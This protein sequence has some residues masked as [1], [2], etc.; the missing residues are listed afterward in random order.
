MAQ[1][2]DQ[3]KRNSVIA[4]INSSFKGDSQPFA[5]PFIKQFIDDNGNFKEGSSAGYGSLGYFINNYLK[6]G[7]PNAISDTAL[8][9][10]LD[11]VTSQGYNVDP[12]Y[13]LSKTPTAG[14][15]GTYTPSTPTAAPGGTIPTQ[16]VPSDVPGQ[17]IPGPN[18]PIGSDRGQIEQEAAREKE[19]TLNSVNQAA[20]LRT[21][22]IS[23]LGDILNKQNQ[24]QFNYDLPGIKEDLGNSGLFTSPSALAAAV[25]RESGMLGANTQSTLAQA[26]LGNIDLQAQGLLGATQA[27]TGM[28]QGGLQRLFS[29]SDYDK[30]AALAREIGAQM[31]PNS[32]SS[33]S[34]ALTGGLGGAASGAMIGSAVPGIGTGIGAGVGGAI[35]L[36]GGATRNGGGG[37]T[38]ICTAMK[39][40]GILTQEEV[41]Q[42]HEHIFPLFP[43]N[44]SLIIAYGIYG[45][46]LVAK[47]L[48]KGIDWQKWK[49]FFFSRVIA[50][51]D[52][53]K[54]FD[55][56]AEAFF[57]LWQEVA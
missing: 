18:I 48:E 50:E 31:V 16:P 8:K 7:N 46:Q 49:D 20:A 6:G 47:C 37:G 3:Q 35:G 13:S 1:Q 14:Q 33:F 36:L 53:S 28:Q 29:V 15:P 32:P 9:P 24:A 10:M 12:S 55:L 41:D 43:K 54:A 4:Q 39:E 57:K 30:Q 27:Q 45:P 26:G 42:I 11:F 51:K 2:G 38:F 44:V 21:Q 40:A 22:G 52:Q 25:A 19:Q 23:S 34:S 5:E 56:Y 17:T